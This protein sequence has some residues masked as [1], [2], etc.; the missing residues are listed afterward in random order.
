MTEIIEKRYME[1]DE[2]HDFVHTC[3]YNSTNQGLSNTSSL[4]E[5]PCTNI[6]KE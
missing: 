2:F 5:R 6:S 4:F 1:R 3:Q